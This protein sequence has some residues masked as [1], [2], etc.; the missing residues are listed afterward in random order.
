MTFCTVG[1]NLTR[2]D[3]LQLEC[4]NERYQEYL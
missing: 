1:I 3:S 4:I 2:G